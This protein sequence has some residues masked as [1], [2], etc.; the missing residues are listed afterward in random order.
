MTFETLPAQRR[1]K[2]GAAGTRFILER[3]GALWTACIQK[4]ILLVGPPGTGKTLLALTLPVEMIHFEVSSGPLRGPGNEAQ[5]FYRRT[6]YRHSE[7]AR[8]G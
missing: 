3:E 2:G 8:G 5:V 6:D 1:G 7:G 4:G